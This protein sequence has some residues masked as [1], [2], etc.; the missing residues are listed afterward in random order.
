[1]GLGFA[2]LRFIPLPEATALR[3]ITP[4]F[5]LIFAAF[6]LGERFK[7]FRLFAVCVGL[8]GVSI[9]MWPSMS[10]DL[11]D[12]AFV[13]VIC[14]L[15]SATLARL[16]QVVV[17]SMSKRKPPRQLRFTSW[18]RLLACRCSRCHLDGWYRREKRPCY[19]LVP[20]LLGALVIGFVVFE[21]IPTSATLFGAALVMCAGSL[22][23]WR[24][25][26]LGKNATAKGK[27]AA[28]AI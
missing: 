18:R 2:G 24:E 13:G 9:I 19:R 28:K 4:V 16:A 27:A 26:M 11:T 5:I 17:R 14:T 15:A 25:R 6:L 1:M 20:A 23:V 10:F 12:L 22:I 8:I 3:F 21:E 7:V